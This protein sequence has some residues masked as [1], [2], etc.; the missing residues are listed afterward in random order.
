MWPPHLPRPSAGMSEQTRREK[1]AAGKK[2]LQ[3][4]QQRKGPDGPGESK[5]RKK[6]KKGG[7][8]K[9]NTTGD[10]HP[11][12][13]AT[14]DHA[15]PRPPWPLGTGGAA[16]GKSV[17]GPS[18]TK[19][20]DGHDQHPELA[21]DSAKFLR[22]CSEIQQLKQEKEALQD[23]QEKELETLACAHEALRAELQQHQLSAQRWVEE[24]LDL[25]AALAHLQQGAEEA[26][27]EQEGL[28]SSLQAAQ[29]RVEELETKLSAVSTT[30]SET[31]LNNLE[32]TKALNRVTLQLQQ[33]SRNCEDLE[34]ENTELRDRLD[35]L[36][37]Q[38]A[39][40]KI[41]INK[42]QRALV[43]RAELERQLKSMRELAT[44]FKLERDSLEKDLRVESSMGKE[45][46]QQ[47]LEEVGR[48]R[49]EKEQGAR[50]VLALEGELGEMREQLAEL[51]RPAGP[52]QA[53]QQLQAQAL[54]LQKELKTLEE[55]LLLQVEENQS[56]RVQ[57]LE[58]QQRLW[59]L[60]KKA[61]EWDQHAEDRRKILETM[62]KEQETK[63]RTLV[64]NRELNE[65][66]AQLQDAWQR[67]SAEKESLAGLLHTEQQEKKHLQEKLEQREETFKEWKEMAEFKRQEAE[68]LQGRSLAQ[69]QQLRAT[70]EQHLAAYQQ[71]SVEKELQQKQ[72]QSTLEDRTV[73][74]EF[75]EDRTVPPEFQE[76]RTVPPKFQEALTCLEATRQENAQLRAQLSLLALSREGGVSRGEDKGEEAAPP[77]VT[78]PE[79]VDNP[80]TMWD[81][82]CA[83]LSVAESKKVQL[84]CELQEQQAH[85]E[86]LAHLA[87]QCQR[88]LEHQALYPKIWNHGVS[89][90]REQDTQEP[91]KWLKICFTYDM[92]GQVDNQSQVDDL[93]RRCSLLSEHIS[94]LEEE[95]ASCE[96][97]M[98]VLGELQREKDE[99][100][101]RLLQEKTEKKEEL[102]GL[103]LRLAG[104][105]TEAGDTR[106]ATALTPAAETPADLPGP[107]ETVVKEQ[108]GFEEEQPE[109]NLEPEQG[110]AGVSGPSV[111]DNPT[112]EQREPPSPDIQQPREPA[113]PGNEHPLPIFYRLMQMMSLT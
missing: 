82:Y 20:M 4:Y 79:D 86:G 32:L 27:L 62:E 67:L 39:N 59:L 112:L 11:T 98:A 8:P 29:Q 16:L 55:Q 28:T 49:E 91:K 100:V 63:R 2:L 18:H 50:Q 90:E 60:E 51:Q 107:E 104:Q 6:T 38:K 30:Q 108:Q 65:Q 3:K 35:A 96:E 45:K 103:L 71:L 76:D 88:K 52:S 19:A 85:C 46:A 113:D 83:A 1:V 94:A 81:F 106:P 36:L 13:G 101:R 66:L 47:L 75:Q 25:Q 84:S 111:V 33:K 40:M 37:T 23:R 9:T 97:Q 42:C 48:L 73:P 12:E 89:G 105:G 92:P 69:L 10:G 109:D 93:P 41:Q 5:K 24:K 61:E 99:R 14:R 95:M 74:P 21:L 31:E 77:A 64:R 7:N 72:V 70:C 68:E 110:E 57:S 15:D 34:D 102:Q 78:V 43:E 56:L 87:A 26:A 54:Q 17:T 58:Q 80:H 22:L 44:T 53:E